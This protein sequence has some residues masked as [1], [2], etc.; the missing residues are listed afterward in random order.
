MRWV[1]DLADPDAT[2]AV[3]PTGQ[4]GHP[5]DPHYDDQTADFLAGVLHP[6]PWSG[7]AVEAVTVSR[8][9]L[10]PGPLP[11]ADPATDPV[12]DPLNDSERR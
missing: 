11:D 2:L 5:R 9:T 6:F 8:L 12:N 3:L 7:E 1:T 4:A 10:E